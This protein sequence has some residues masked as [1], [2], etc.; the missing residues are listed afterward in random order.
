MK[1]LRLPFPNRFKRGERLTLVRE[2]LSYKW[3]A[4]FQIAQQLRPTL[5]HKQ[6]MSTLEKLDLRGDLD[7]YTKEHVAYFRLTLDVPAP[8][9]AVD[10]P[11][12]CKVSLLAIDSSQQSV[13]A[14]C[15]LCGWKGGIS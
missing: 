5:N 14:R 15:Q 4:S 12:C 2:K 11:H 3:Q 10:C 7:T 1:Q 8:L 6:T 13:T 9:H